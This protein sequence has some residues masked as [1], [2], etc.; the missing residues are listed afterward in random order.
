M[1]IMHSKTP[2]SIMKNG[3]E[4]EDDLFRIVIN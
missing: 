1:S 3:E 4:E 2:P